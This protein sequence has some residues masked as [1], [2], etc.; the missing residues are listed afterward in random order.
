[1]K[2]RRLFASF[3]ATCLL[4]SITQAQVA[5]LGSAPT[6]GR[7]KQVGLFQRLVGGGSACCDSG[8][9]DGCASCLPEPGCGM[10]PT[11]GLAG[12][13]LGGA[14]C[15]LPQPSCGSAGLG[16]AGGFGLCGSCDSSCGVGG[17]IGRNIRQVNPY[18]CGGSLIADMARGFLCLVDRT[19]GSVVGGL[20]GGLQAVTCHA[21]G[22]L[23]ALQCAA[24]A[25]CHAC[26][27]VGCDGCGM[28][29]DHGYRDTT[30]YAPHSDSEYLPAPM[31]PTPA[32]EPMPAQPQPMEAD[33]FTDDPPPEVSR[34]PR[35]LSLGN[36][37]LGVRQQQLV[38]PVGH[39][40]PQSSPRIGTAVQNTMR[41]VRRA[42]ANMVA[43][44][45]QRYLQ[46]Q[47]QRRNMV[48]RR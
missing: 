40:V 6:G 25:S 28:P 27:T 45:Q 11:C 16:Y 34:R 12:R 2:G 30:S 13:I 41:S 47:I 1:M 33:P 24:Q 29:Y 43:P 39:Q 15:G 37:G 17:Y 22:T 48:L 38:R 31:D 9:V 26:G 18:V 4:A 10:G 23:A 32:A 14:S 7:I 3:V 35:P 8:C 20:F 42:T 21:S 44:V 46:S 36:R 19:V 5:Q